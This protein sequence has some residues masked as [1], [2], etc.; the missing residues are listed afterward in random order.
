MTL[1]ELKIFQQLL[2]LAEEYANAVASEYATS[3][4][5]EEEIKNDPRIVAARQL[6]NEIVG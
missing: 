3:T 4:R 5:E 6:L 1:N 2:D